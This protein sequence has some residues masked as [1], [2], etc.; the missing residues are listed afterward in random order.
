MK[1]MAIRGMNLFRR[2]HFWALLFLLKPDL[3][4]AQT[5]KSMPTQ[6][7]LNQLTQA[8]AFPSD[9]LHLTD[10]QTLAIKPLANPPEN[11]A[12]ITIEIIPPSP[13]R[14]SIASRD[15]ASVAYFEDR[16]LTHFDQTFGKE[17]NGPAAA[18]AERLLLD[19]WRKHRQWRISPSQGQNPWHKIQAQITTRLEFVQADYLRALTAD[20]DLTDAL[21]LAERLLPGYAQP[22]PVRSAIA[23]VWLRRAQQLADQGQ[24][25]AARNQRMRLEELDAPQIAKEAGK[26]FAAI[27][28]GLLAKARTTAG[29]A[30]EAYLRQADLLSPN[31]PELDEE[32]DRRGG[33]TPILRISVP[34][35]PFLLSP[36][37]AA[38][39][40][41]QLVASLV[42]ETLEQK[43]PLLPRSGL[44]ELPPGT[45]WSDG[46]P[47]VSSDVQHAVELLSRPDLPGRSNWRRKFLDVRGVAN[48]PRQLNLILGQG[49]W[50]AESLFQ[51][52]LI[53]GQIR[54]K[55]LT[56]ADD[57]VLANMPIGTGP[58]RWLG[59]RPG[60]AEL[61]P[62]LRP[63]SYSDRAGSSFGE[64]RLESLAKPPAALGP[65]S[66]HLVYNLS[67]AEA[68]AWTKAGY[69][70]R[71]SPPRGTIMLAIN[72]R[73]PALRDVNLRRALAHAIHRRRILTDYFADKG[74][75]LAQPVNGPFRADTWPVCPPPRVPADLY[76]PELARTWAKKAEVAAPQL[77]LHYSKEDPLAGHA[78]QAIAEQIKQGLPGIGLTPVGLTPSQFRRT[79]LQRQ[80]ALAYLPLDAPE[81]LGTLWSIFDT[82]PEALEAGG[83]NFLGYDNDA[84]LQILLGDLFNH[85]QFAILQGKFHDLHVHLHE[86][87]PF[88]PLWQAPTLSA[89]HPALEIPPGDGNFSWHQ[90]PYWKLTRP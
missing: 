74:Q 30:G 41:E 39:D 22:G 52:P 72:H 53:P 4:I 77:T 66:P 10:G 88:I 6:A 64:I 44:V 25:L 32:W 31:I 8:L 5:T 57:P 76:S 55:V 61:G 85:R 51:F 7:D 37:T 17:L 86:R 84:Q 15:I 45:W 78:C 46:R 42:F 43:I 62:I 2:W 68:G 48:Q 40:G 56:R 3:A 12:T 87:M 50:R 24:W 26:H 27:V 38:S 23:E 69:R 9:R 35:L 80:F 29:A 13:D 14:G 47:V 79:I 54:G 71:A 70:L 28:E 49:F 11:E 33:R 82:H 34:G 60:K 58:F 83:S 89:V 67:A 18:A 19:C 21:A 59:R 63:N 1:T 75:I 81:E 20:A 65:A 90:L 36:A 73:V 16:W